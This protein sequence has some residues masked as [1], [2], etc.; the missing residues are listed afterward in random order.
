MSAKTGPII[1]V[2][3]IFCGAVCLVVGVNNGTVSEEC[4]NETETESIA[5]D[6][7]RKKDSSIAEG[8]EIVKTEGQKG[9]KIKIYKVCYKGGK[10]VSKNFENEL[11]VKRPVDEVI[12]VGT[13]HIYTGYCAVE[14]TYRRRYAHCYGDYSPEAKKNA[15]AQA[16][17]C[18]IN[19]RP[20]QG[21]YNVYY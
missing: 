5:Y 8:K 19:S 12:L 11:I 16:R 21:C 7:I 13:K 6:V 9:E 15:E 2:S 20:V 18:N 14:G 3:L 1:F 17:Y 4:K 10:E